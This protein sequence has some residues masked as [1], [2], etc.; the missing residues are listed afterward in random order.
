MLQKLVTSRTGN[1]EY[2]MDLRWSIRHL[3]FSSQSGNQFPDMQHPAFKL[4]VDTTSIFFNIQEAAVT[5]IRVCFIRSI[6]T[7]E[8]FLLPW[9]IFTPC[10]FDRAFFA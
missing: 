8:F 1:N 9:C 10:R 6:F 7:V 3:E 2:R 5:K 4:K